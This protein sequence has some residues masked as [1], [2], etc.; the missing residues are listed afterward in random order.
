[1]LTDDYNAINGFLPYGTSL[2][3]FHTFFLF[4]VEMSTTLECTIDPRVISH[5]EFV[6]RPLDGEDFGTLMVA[7]YKQTFLPLRNNPAKQN[8]SRPIQTALVGTIEETTFRLCVTLE[9][10]WGVWTKRVVRLLGP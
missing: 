9:Y 4:Q 3:F 2:H 8:V 5:P 10:G 7:E 1:L 6:H